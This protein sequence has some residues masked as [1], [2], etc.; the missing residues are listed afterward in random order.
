MTR[1]AQ[2]KIHVRYWDGFLTA[3]WEPK[4]PVTTMAS[5]PRTPIA[6]VIARKTGERPMASRTGAASRG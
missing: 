2:K 5:R 1:P 6:P 3:V 4:R